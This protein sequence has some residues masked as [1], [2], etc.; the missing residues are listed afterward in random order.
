MVK[1]MKKKVAV[2]H[3]YIPEKATE[4]EQDVIEQVEGISGALKTIGFDPVPVKFDLNLEA[5]GI[6]LKMLKPEFVF[7]LVE[8]VNARGSLIHLAPSFLDYLGIPYTGSKTEAMFL[9]SNKVVSKKILTG[10][11]MNTPKYFTLSSLNQDTPVKGRFIIKSAWEHASI[12]LSQDSVITVESASELISVLKKSR[13][14]MK[15]DCFCEEYIEG[16]EFNVGMLFGENG[17]EVLPPGEIIFVD[18][19][20]GKLKIVDYRA[21]WK[22]KSFEYIHTD[23]IYEFGREDDHIIKSIKSI[24]ADCWKLFGLKGY[25]RVDFRVDGSG[26]PWVL[27]VNANPCLSPEGGFSVASALVGLDYPMIVQRIID[28]I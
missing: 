2:L 26:K 24:S 6:T 10:C 17:I 19:P 20:P 12:G 8:S 16:R 13:K 28:D 4:D 9:T 27:E 7:N 5:V 11:G 22:M 1:N 15:G 25:A 23:R 14:R 3:P 18:Y 21:K